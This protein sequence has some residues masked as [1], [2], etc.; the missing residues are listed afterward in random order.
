M[1][2]KITPNNLL[3]EFQASPSKSYAHRLIIATFLAGKGVVKNVGSSSDIKATLAVIKALG[4][5]YKY[6]GTDLTVTGIRPVLACECNC[7]DS[8]ST[9]RFMVSIVSALGIKATFCG[10]KGLMNRPMEGLFTC[11][12]ER[13]AN[14]R[15]YKVKGKLSAGVFQIDGEVSSQYISG[16]LFA[17]P[18]LDGDS[19]IVIKG[20]LVSKGYID[21]TLDVLAK[22][23]IEINVSE[24]GY[25]VK[26]NQKYVCPEGLKT[27]GDYSSAACFLAAGAIGG[28]VTANNLE[29]NSC[30]GDRQIV[31]ILK[32]FG[33]NVEINENSVTVSPNKLVGITLDVENNLDLAQI[34]SVVAFFAEGVTTL[35][36]VNRLKFKES[37]RLLAIMNMAEIAGIKTEYSENSIKIYGGKP[38]GGMFVC[39]LDHRTAMS[40]SILACYAKGHSTIVGA[41]AVQKSYTN[42]YNDLKI[43]GGKF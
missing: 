10:S 20:N 5:V 36:S 22:F 4:A 12:N 11:L 18:L 7:A 14:I 15:D 2:V 6:N 9:L 30:Q 37:D 40:T 38:V 1:N 8:A 33:A 25:I 32:K 39:E 16:L 29:K 3:G 31:N 23:G 41:E 42:F 26:G 21:I 35:N 34:I 24:K 43:L 17:L 27:E 28:R 13:G 19:E